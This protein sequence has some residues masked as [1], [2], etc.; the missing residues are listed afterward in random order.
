[1]R[2]QS[3]DVYTIA[4]STARASLRSVPAATLEAIALRVAA[5]GIPARV[6]A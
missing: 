3:V 4:R 5:L 2:P 1:V 6:F